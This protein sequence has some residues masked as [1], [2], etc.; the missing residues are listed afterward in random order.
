MGLC[1]G[2]LTWV[3]AGTGA[4]VFPPLGL[5]PPPAAGLLLVTFVG[6]GLS[7]PSACFVGLV[8]GAGEGLLDAG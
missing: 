8:M 1:P 4:E 6:V 3:V 5:S 7:P 2:A